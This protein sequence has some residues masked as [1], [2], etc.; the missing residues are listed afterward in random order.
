MGPTASGKT[1]C[2]C[3][4]YD[5]FRCELISVDAAQVYRNMNI[6]TAKPDQAFLHRYPHHLIDIRHMDEKYSAA[7]FCADASGLIAEIHQRGNTPVLVGGTMFYF[8]ALENGLSNLPSADMNLRSVI[9]MEIRE[10]GISA[11]YQELSDVDP[12][13]ARRI[14]PFDSQRIQRA[15]ELYRL[16][17]VPPSELMTR[18]NMPA[19]TNP[20]IKIALFTSDRKTLH[21]QIEHRFMQMLEAGLIN[22]VKAIIR[23]QD[24]PRQL[25]SMR[26]IGYRQ[27]LEFLYDKVDYQK[28]LDNGAAATRQLAKRQLTWM[29]NQSNL[30]WFDLSHA[31]AINALL[32]YLRTQPLSEK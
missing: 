10:K 25:T 5:E 11:L 15:V 6:G 2:A 13:S 18:S 32:E 29:R 21:R 28:M 19:L 22:E 1:R 20:I 8:S 17:R 23:D 9:D 31:R 7:A 30:V 14:S 3:R 4:I 16:T 26:A 12:R 27:V 24:N